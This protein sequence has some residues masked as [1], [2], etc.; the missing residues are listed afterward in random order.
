MNQDFHAVAAAERGRRVLVKVG[1]SFEVGDHDFTKFSIIPSVVLK[2]QILENVAC[3]WYCG[4]V[5][6]TFKNGAFESSS[7][8]RHM[9]ELHSILDSQHS[10]KKALLYTQTEGQITE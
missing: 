1:T 6:V 2:N 8:M 7:P 9:A 10:D 5:F 3:S 4:K